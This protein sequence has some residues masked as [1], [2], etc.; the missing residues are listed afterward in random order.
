MGISRQINRAI[1]ILN[2]SI[3]GIA[4]TS[5]PAKDKMELITLARNT[6]DTTINQLINAGSK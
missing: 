5:I 3:S 4:K 2:K 6:F 1:F